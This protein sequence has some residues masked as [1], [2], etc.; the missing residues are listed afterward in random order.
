MAC[1]SLLGLSQIVSMHGYVCTV[2]MLFLKFTPVDTVVGTYT[3]EDKDSSTLFYN[4]ISDPVGAYFIQLIQHRH[5]DHLFQ[6][7]MMR[8]LLCFFFV[9]LLVQRRMEYLNCQL[10][11]AQ[12]LS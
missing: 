4:L 12:T 11:P 1:Y 5:L 3:A 8:V 7:H 10:S 6:L 2:Y 9:F